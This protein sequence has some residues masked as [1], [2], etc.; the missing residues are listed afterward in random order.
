MRLTE[1]IELLKEDVLGMEEKE[2]DEFI[3]DL[4]EHAASLQ[5]KADSHDKLD[6]VISGFY[7]N[8]DREEVGEEY[9]LLDIGEAVA[10]HFGWM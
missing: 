9:D 7:V 2:L 3:N 5:R 8:D 10:I 4:A 1:K 6:E